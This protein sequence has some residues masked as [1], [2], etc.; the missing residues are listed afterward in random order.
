M[1]PPNKSLVVVSTTKRKYQAD[2]D[3]NEAIE[4]QVHRNV[5]LMGEIARYQE[6]SK[7]DDEEK[8]RMSL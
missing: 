6:K 4:E 8:L 7:S 2:Y 3:R 1:S 5:E